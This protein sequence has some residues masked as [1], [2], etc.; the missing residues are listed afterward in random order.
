MEEKVAMARS[1]KMITDRTRRATAELAESWTWQEVR[2]HG[3]E[4][5]TPASKKAT[6][7]A[8]RANQKRESMP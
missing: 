1:G 3:G 7:N 4:V 2:G 6:E 5:A 8:A